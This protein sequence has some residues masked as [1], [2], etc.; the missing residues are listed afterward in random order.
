MREALGGASYEDFQSSL[1][2]E[3]PSSGV[4]ALGIS[5]DFLHLLVEEVHC[6][7]TGP[8]GGT[9]EAES[10]LRL[11]GVVRVLGGGISFLGV[12]GDCPLDLGVQLFIVLSQCREYGLAATR[13]EDLQLI[14]VQADVAEQLLKACDEELEIHVR[15]GGRGV[16]DPTKGMRDGAVAI[17]S[18]VP[19][20]ET[21]IHAGSEFRQQWLQHPVENEYLLQS[22]ERAPLVGTLPHPYMLSWTVLPAVVRAPPGK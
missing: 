3:V 15:N 12:V 6:I 5:P 17:I 7:V 13:C 11:N 9:R 18:H 19:C 2:L 20:Y 10:G 4:Q 22:R 16:I 8:N 1:D 21:G 14:L